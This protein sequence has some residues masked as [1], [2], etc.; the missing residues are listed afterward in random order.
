MSAGIKFGTDG[1]RA[2][3]AEDFTF[4]N[5]RACA[6]GVADFLKTAGTG[7]KGL[8]IG[9]DTRFASED[10]AA[11]AAEVIAGNGIKVILLSKAAP[12]PVT[13]YTLTNLKAAGGIMIT[14]SHN[15]AS[16]NGFKYKVETGSSAPTEVISV[17]EKGA[18]E[19]VTSGKINRV[20]LKDAIKKKSVAFHDPY[21][22][23][24]K[25]LGK[26][27]DLEALRQRKLQ[28]VADSMFGAG[29]GY[30]KSL[31]EGGQIDIHEINRV[32]NPLFPG[33]QPEPIS[34]NLGKLAR[35]VIRDNAAVGLATDGDADRI[36]MVDENGRYRNTQEVFALLAMYFLDVRKERGAIVKTLTST[37]MLYKIGEL[38][39]VPVFETQVGFKYVAPIMI[40]ENALL[41]GEESGGYAFRGH[42][43]ERD[44]MLA[45]LFLLDYIAR[46]GKSPSQLLADLYKKVGPHYYDRVDVHLTEESSQKARAAMASLGEIDKIGQQKVVNLNKIDGFR[47]KLEDGAWL[48]IRFS[49]TEPLIRIY[50]ESSSAEEVQKLIQDGQKIL[51]V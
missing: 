27:I 31:L 11:A 50:A 46:T 3:I 19:A 26:L 7:S 14:A 36:G 9:Y 38:Y 5:V 32:R 41:G 28:I 17:I 6:Q 25:H 21:H 2:V 8:V 29:I 48:L 44:G 23:Y 34:K 1:W 40:A 45:G 10:F 13:S 43:P 37:D 18:N 24:A 42:I 47:Y 20:E 12:T 39:K 22:A 35:H 30:F 4:G 49:G 33:I 16:Y 15:P 51:G